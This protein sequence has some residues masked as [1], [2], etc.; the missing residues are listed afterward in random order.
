MLKDRK[1]VSVAG[2]EVRKKVPICLGE[3]YLPWKSL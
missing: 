2:N 1:E 3:G